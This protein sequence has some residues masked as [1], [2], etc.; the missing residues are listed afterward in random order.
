MPY[1]PM[2][3][4][5][6]FDHELEDSPILRSLK[7]KSSG[8]YQAPDHYFDQMQA[9]LMDKLE[10]E[11]ILAQAPALQRAGKGFPFAVPT[12]YFDSLPGRIRQKIEGMSSPRVVSMRARWGYA[13]LAL[14]AAL[15]LLLLLRSA[16]PQ[17]ASTAGDAL[18]WEEIPT[19]DLLALVVEENYDDDMIFEVLGDEH[20]LLEG[21]TSDQLEVEDLSSD[22]L[23]QL[24]D[25][26]DLEDLEEAW[27]ESGEIEG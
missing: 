26:I 22:E 27:L 8:E 24:L 21:I 17:E 15:A 16:V 11:E 25:D 1:K 19:E 7:E 9:S 2:F 10:D 6:K 12:G 14:A 13:T 18:A 5:D 4:Q 23:D 3:P 20:E